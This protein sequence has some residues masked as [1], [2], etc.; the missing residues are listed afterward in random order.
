MCKLCQ[1]KPIYIDASGRKICQK[2]FGHFY[3]KKVLKTIRRFGL[4]GDEHELCIFINAVDCCSFALLHFMYKY[5]MQRRKN[6]VVVAKASDESLEAYCKQ[7][8]ISLLSSAVEKLRP[9]KFIVATCLNDVAE[10]IMLSLMSRRL[11]KKLKELEVW[12]IKEMFVGKRKV[13]AVMPLFFCSEEE[14]CLYCKVNGIEARPHA[15]SNKQHAE[16]KRFLQS[17]EK[18]HNVYHAIVNAF[19]EIARGKHF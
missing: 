9:K 8:G 7:K 2:H 10:H 14:S 11:G 19:L 16:L 12:P 15:P 17:L 4:I 1:T 6:I 13:K 3:E 5:A 18:K